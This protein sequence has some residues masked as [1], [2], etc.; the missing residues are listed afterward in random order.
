MSRSLR[1]ADE[2]RD[3][4]VEGLRRLPLR[5]VAGAGNDLHRAAPEGRHGERGEIGAVD[6]LSSAPC[7]T[8]S[9][10]FRSRTT[11]TWSR[12]PPGARLAARNLRARPSAL[13]TS[14]RKNGGTSAK[15]GANIEATRAS[16][17][18]RSMRSAVTVFITGL[19]R[20]ASPID[21]GEPSGGVPKI[22]KPRASGKSGAISST[23]W[24]PRLQP[25]S[26]LA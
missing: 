7:S 10:A 5:G 3:D 11:A 18:S 16:A 2:L 23:T 1:L 14:S 12:K 15:P 20:N 21:G 9:G 4:R 26:A 6:E 25:T 19:G 17:R 13:T 22:M 8:A 24:P